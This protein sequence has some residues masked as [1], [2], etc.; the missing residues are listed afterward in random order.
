MAQAVPK[1]N[2]RVCVLGRREEF[3][4]PKFPGQACD[5][6]MHSHMNLV[7]A[8]FL[9]DQGQAEW[10]HTERISAKG[11]PRPPLREN[12]IRLVPRRTWKGKMSVD[13]A[14][15]MRVMQLVQ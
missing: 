1:R 14:R 5:S 6:R 12:A 2:I 7:G 10:V 13:G 15:S 3:V 4:E 9:V 8:D 11:K